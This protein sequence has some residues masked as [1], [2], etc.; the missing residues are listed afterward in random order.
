MAVWK[1][2]GLMWVA[3]RNGLRAMRKEVQAASRSQRKQ[4]ETAP[5][6]SSSTL[7]I[8]WFEPTQRL[9][10]EFCPQALLDHE[11]VW[12]KATTFEICYSTN[13]KLTLGETGG[14]RK[15]PTLDWS[16]H[17]KSEY[18]RALVFLF[19][20]MGD[21]ITFLVQSVTWRC[22]WEYICRLCN[23][24]ITDGKQYP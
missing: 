1:A 13:K 10:A 22:N 16:S 8:P 18:C 7:P 24:R 6:V 5:E 12:F 19:Y 9:T 23:W 4:E 14:K 3:V 2:I 21:Y 20:K 15:K 11:C 17:S